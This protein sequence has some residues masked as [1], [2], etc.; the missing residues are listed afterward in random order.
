MPRSL[1]GMWFYTWRVLDAAHWLSFHSVV[2]IIVCLKTQFSL[3]WLLSFHCC[4]NI[5]LL[6]GAFSC[7]VFSAFNVVIILCLNVQLCSLLSFLVLQR[8]NSCSQSRG[9]CSAKLASIQLLVCNV[10]IREQVSTSYVQDLPNTKKMVWLPGRLKN[11][12]KQQ[13]AQSESEI[14]SFSFSFGL[15]MLSSSSSTD[16]ELVFVPLIAVHCQVKV[17]LNLDLYNNS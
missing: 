11:S 3:L 1:W 2:P 8:I 10:N 4:N 16:V 12:P 6:I 7:T 17:N 14:L 13:L 5:L 15:F 9:F